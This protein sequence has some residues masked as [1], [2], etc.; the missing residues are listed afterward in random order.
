VQRSWIVM[1]IVIVV[2]VTIGIVIAAI[3]LWF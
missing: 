1:Q 2:L 3:K